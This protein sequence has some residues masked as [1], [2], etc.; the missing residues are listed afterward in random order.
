MT[1]P[2]RRVLVTGTASGIGR[3]LTQQLT[4][5]GAQVTSL[6]RTR[7]TADVAVHVDVD[8]ADQEAVDRALSEE[9]G[10]DPWDAVCNVAGLADDEPPERVFAV[11]FLAVRHICEALIGRLRPGAAIVNVASTSG[12]E[13]PQHLATLRPLLA[14]NGFAEGA[15][16]FADHGAQWHAEPLS[17]EALVAYTKARGPE[18]VPR[19]LRMNAVSPGPVDTPL[20]EGFRR[21]M[22]QA[23][24]DEARLHFGGS[25]A[26]NDIA[27]IVAFLSSPD[28]VAINGHNII[29]DGG[30]L[31]RC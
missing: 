31:G 13:W 10:S 7:P 9:R 23:Y 19:G 22:D 27:R 17:K 28:S 1:P 21:N 11:N 5:Q 18:L 26:A 30:L 3:A 12:H 29:A 25:F 8:L 16:W 6:D 14:T 2:Q 20:L 24:L 15:R 4:N